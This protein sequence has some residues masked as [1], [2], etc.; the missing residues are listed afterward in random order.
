MITSMPMVS[1][2]ICLVRAP[3]CLPPAVLSI[4]FVVQWLTGHL[5]RISPNIFKVNI[6]KY[7]HILLS[8]PLSCQHSPPEVFSCPVVS[9][10]TQI[11]YL[12]NLRVVLNFIFEVNSAVRSTS[13]SPAVSLLECLAVFQWKPTQI[14]SKKHGHH[15]VFYWSFL[16]EKGNT[17][18]TQRNIFF[19][20]LQ[21]SRQLLKISPASPSFCFW[22]YPHHHPQ[23]HPPS[24]IFPSGHLP[25]LITCSKFWSLCT[26]SI[27][28][29]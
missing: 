1:T 9:S 19:L 29:V 17:L 27:K 16:V 2:L 22:L 15:V 25:G 23:P 3:N 28:E 10:S 21:S 4:R 12:N 26:S 6:F 5:P 18:Q 24:W 8:P 14:N 20:K 13:K 11:I 7:G